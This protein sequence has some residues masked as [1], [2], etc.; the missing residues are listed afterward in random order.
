MRAH[1]GWATFVN[2]PK[3]RPR[4]MIVLFDNGTKLLVFQGTSTI[5]DR[6][7][8]LVIEPMTRIAAAWRT[9]SQPLS[10]PTAFAPVA[11]SIEPSQ[12]ALP[13]GGKLAPIPFRRLELMYAERLSSN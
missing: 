7:N 2:D 6:E 12:I 1:V 9:S 4:P 13:I 5:R 11:I 8:E 3:A 10:N